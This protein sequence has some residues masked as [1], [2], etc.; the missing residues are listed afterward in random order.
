MSQ[1]DMDDIKKAIAAID[2]KKKGLRASFVRGG[3]TGM[4]QTNLKKYPKKNSVKDYVYPGIK[5]QIKANNKHIDIVFIHGLTSSYYIVEE[6]AEFI[7]NLE[8]KKEYVENISYFRT[9][10]GKSE[11]DKFVKKLQERNKGYIFLDMIF[12]KTD[13]IMRVVVDSSDSK[14]IGTKY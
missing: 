10:I 12:P 3:Q 8:N 6:D 1:K 11:K 9:S 5:N 13:P 14:L 4:V 2:A 7:H